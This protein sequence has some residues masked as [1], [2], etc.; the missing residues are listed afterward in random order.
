[1]D[2]G[3]RICDA[4]FFTLA[5]QPQRLSFGFARRNPPLDHGGNYDAH[6]LNVGFG[7]PIAW[8]GHYY[9]RA[10]ESRSSLGLDKQ[11]EIRAQ[12]ALQDWSA[13]VLPQASLGQTLVQAVATI[14]CYPLVVGASRVAFGVRKPATGETDAYGRRL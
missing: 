14:L 8:K 3:G 11:D 6:L 7:I 5:Q 10:G 4:E 12:T 13:Q 9:A 1:M 2:G